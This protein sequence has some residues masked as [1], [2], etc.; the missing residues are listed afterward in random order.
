MPLT[1]G[2]VAF[3]TNCLVA[4]LSAYG[5]QRFLREPPWFGTLRNAAIYVL[6][7]ALVSPAISALGGAFVQILGGGPATNYWRF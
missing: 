2:L 4:I 5:V 1:Q 6:I 7:T 3:A